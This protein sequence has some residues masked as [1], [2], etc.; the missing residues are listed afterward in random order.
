MQHFTHY[1]K[2]FM[3]ALFLWAIALGTTANAAVIETFIEYQ[4]GCPIPDPKTTSVA[5]TDVTDEI[6]AEK[7]KRNREDFLT[8]AT[9]K[10]PTSFQHVKGFEDRIIYNGSQIEL[11]ITG[12]SA[13][14]LEGSHRLII[15]RVTGW[16][17]FETHDVSIEAEAQQNR[18][19]TPLD[20]SDYWPDANVP[21]FI[22]ILTNDN[23]DHIAAMRVT[24]FERLRSRLKSPPSSQTPQHQVNHG[25]LNHSLSGFRQ[26][27]VI[28]AES[29]VMI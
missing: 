19:N 16:D 6:R 27:L 10:T 2:S 20:L 18:I 15:Q 25:Q 12:S 3:S 17:T 7:L 26:H 5:T 22:V 4:L 28:F 24:F 9:A 21:L 14:Q 13:D 11:D 1:K 8:M 29:S 23:G